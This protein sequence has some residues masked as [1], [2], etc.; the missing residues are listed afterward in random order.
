Y[1]G[2]PGGPPAGD[3][4]HRAGCR[5]PGGAAARTFPQPGGDRRAL[6]LR[7]E[8][9]A[10]DAGG[11][12]RRALQRLAEC[13]QSD[14]ES[15]PLTDTSWEGRAAP[16]SIASAASTS[17]SS[18]GTATT[19]CSARASAYRLQAA[20]NSAAISGPITKP[21]RPNSASPPRVEIS[22]T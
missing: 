13:G 1:A 15:A 11:A 7:P 12:S 22:T 16:A 20:I 5:L 9:P 18:V 6:G 14:Q 4:D 10:S 17:S 2:R 8:F 19:S 21:L 3:G